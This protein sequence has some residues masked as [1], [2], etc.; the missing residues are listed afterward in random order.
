MTTQNIEKPDDMSNPQHVTSSSS[1]P[2]VAALWPSAL[3]GV[4]LVVASMVLAFGWSTA[5]VEKAGGPSGGPQGAM[6][7]PAGGGMGRESKGGKGP[8]AAKEGTDAATEAKNIRAQ[9]TEMR[10][11]VTSKNSAGEIF[12]PTRA[13]IRSE[14]SGLVDTLPIRIGTRVARGAI[15]AKLRD[16]QKALD[17]KKQEAALLSAKARAKRAAVAVERNQKAWE[18]REAL[19]EAGGVSAAELDDLQ[20][21]LQLAQSDAEVAAA[22]IA[23]AETA[24]ATAKVA[25]EDLVIRAPFAGVV[26]HVSTSV[27]S[28]LS[29]RDAVAEIIDD[30]D[31]WLRF[32]VPIDDVLARLDQ[33][34]Q[35]QFRGHL[36]NA[37]VK[38][39]NP[40]LT[41]S[42]R[43][44]SVEAKVRIDPE[45]QKKSAQKLPIGALVDVGTAA[46]SVVENRIAVP[47]AALV[48]DGDNTWI[49]FVEEKAPPPDQGKPANSA[50]T[51][52]IAHRRAVRL[53]ADDGVWAAIDGV[54][55][56]VLVIFAGLSGLQEG[57]VVNALP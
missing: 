3:A 27:G 21:N 48:R 17:V 37:D 6:K 57:S 36:W 35:I 10:A 5:P 55:A 50:A 15:L 52:G 9:R 49:W 46:G 32:E 53:L 39:I 54:D 18:R 28:W 11:M 51:S 22:D 2:P 38:Y 34:I 30:Q 45:N 26:V 14:G 16:P 25:Q 47:S 12:A 41:G 33:S 7:G 20:T 29:Q 1:T 23:Q 4:A 31:V 44:Q 42:R 43:Y 19:R 56:G 13:T 24:L 40:V 8:N